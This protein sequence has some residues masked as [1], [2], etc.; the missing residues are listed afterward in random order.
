MKDVQGPGALQMGAAA[1]G[2]AFR[3][4]ERVFFR[5]VDGAFFGG[6]D[7]AFFRQDLRTRLPVLTGVSGVLGSDRVVGLAVTETWT[8]LAGLADIGVRDR[9]R[10]AGT[11]QGRR[12]AMSS[13]V[14]VCFGERGDGGE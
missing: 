6:V 5:G 13:L 4:V 9:A 14:T 3:G 7:G 1:F 11:Q 12:S 2:V 8:G 10:P